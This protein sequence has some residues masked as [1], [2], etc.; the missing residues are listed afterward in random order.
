[1][2]NRVTKAVTMDCEMV[3]VDED[4]RQDM[5]VR[6]SIVKQYGRCVSSMVYRQRILLLLK[7]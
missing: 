3:G 2:T 1:M 6:V 7:R 5:L 4:G